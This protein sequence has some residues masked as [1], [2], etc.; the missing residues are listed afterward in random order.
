VLVHRRY[1]RPGDRVLFAR[2]PASGPPDRVSGARAVGLA[3][4]MTCAWRSIAGEG[5][6]AFCCHRGRAGRYSWC[7][8]DARRSPA[9]SMPVRK[10][11]SA[12]R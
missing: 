9:P 5:L 6:L 4:V 7:A 8:T 2:L 1:C 10:Y 3:G 12:R 11:Y